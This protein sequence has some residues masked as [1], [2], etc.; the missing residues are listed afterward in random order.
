M[1]VEDIIS[2]DEIDRVH[3]YASFGDISKRDV[4]RYGLLKCA[5]GYHQGHTTGQ[6]IKEHGLVG[7]N[8]T[9]TKKGRRYLWAAF[10]E[11]SV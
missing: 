1:K 5:S 9:L 8:M 3:A 11:I 4:V 10:G 2:D 6:I 7:K